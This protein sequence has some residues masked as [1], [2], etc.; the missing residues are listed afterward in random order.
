[1]SAFV[2]LIDLHFLTDHAIAAFLIDSAEGPVLVET[3]PY[4]T[5]DHLKKGVAAAGHDFAAIR[6]VLL[7]H[8]HFDHAGAAWALAAQGA[9]IYVHPFGQRHLHD[10]EKLYNSARRIYGD[11][12][13]ILW[14]AMEGIPEAQ[15]TTPGHG[16]TVTIGE[17]TFTA[18]HT[19]GHAKHHIAW[20]WGTS[21]FTGDVAGCA[22]GDGP[23]VPPC[24][25]PDI[26][27]E[28]WKASIQLLRDLSPQS[29]YLT[30]YGPV[31][32]VDTHLDQLERLLDDWARF[33]K[34]G[35]DAGKDHAA[36]TP[37]FTRYVE[38]QLRA[39][40]VDNG[41]LLRYEAANPSYMSVAGLMRY[42]QKKTE[43][44]S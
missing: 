14:G 21:I 19:P 13:E 43:E 15:L 10:P 2:E 6:H 38:Q 44:A 40:G 12:M 11:Q 5:I 4:S 34:Q 8:I 16:D 37:E 35:M 39:A 18:W 3:G 42:W 30:H 7:T 9:Q 17:H 22:I 32:D 31:T 20:Q 24:P 33:I 1:M 41:A 36:L 25:P 23:V 29:L 26:D 28:A 27:I